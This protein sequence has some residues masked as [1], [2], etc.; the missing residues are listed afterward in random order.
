MGMWSR[1]YRNLLAL[2][3]YSNNLNPIP[4]VVHINKWCINWG[5]HICNWYVIDMWL[6]CDIYIYIHMYSPENRAFSIELYDIYIYIHTYTYCTLYLRIKR[7]DRS[8]YH[9]RSG[10]DKMR[11]EH[12]LGG[13]FNLEQH[14]R[15]YPLV[16]WHSYGKSPFLVG[17]STINGSFP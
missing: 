6:I 8:K 15:D 14:G 3:Y 10:Y 7:G 2:I 1:I 4:W 9:Q 5:V 17:K 16:I 12:Y 13:G 11:N